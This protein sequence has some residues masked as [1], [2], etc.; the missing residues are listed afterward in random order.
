MEIVLL[1]KTQ[2]MKNGGGKGRSSVASST[3]ARNS[4]NIFAMQGRTSLSVWVVHPSLSIDYFLQE[5]FKS[6]TPILAS[7][8]YRLSWESNTGRQDT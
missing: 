8:K 6:P 2:Q 3:Q 4:P 7:V 5:S 1:L